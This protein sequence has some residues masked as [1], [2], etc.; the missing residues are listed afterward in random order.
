MM[1]PL[2]V[3]A[4]VIAILQLSGKIISA[5]I[6]YISSVRD[7]PKDLRTIMVEIQSLQ[8]IVRVMDLTS[9]QSTRVDDGLGAP[10][11]ACRASLKELSDLLDHQTTQSSPQVGP[12]AKK[13]KTLP[14]LSSLAWP[15]KHR[16][17]KALMEDISRHKATITLSL[18]ANWR[19]F[20]LALLY[21]SILKGF[22]RLTV[23]TI[24]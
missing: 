12:P 10:L 21:A 13:S 2:S 22:V 4:S 17:V 5:C 1:D 24:H 18:T 14:T 11:E 7:A 20:L 23:V 15:L 6:A 16:R 9:S 19:Y 3:S 8:A